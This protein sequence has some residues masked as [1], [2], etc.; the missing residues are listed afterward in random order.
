[1]IFKKHLEMKRRDFI[2]KSMA[3]TAYAALRT[4]APGVPHAGAARA[5][6]RDM[7]KENGLLSAMESSDR[8]AV[9]GALEKELRTPD[10]ALKIH[11]KI[12]PIA[13]RVLNPPFI[14][15]HLPK[16][17]G[18][19]RELMALVKRK[20]LPA[21]VGLEVQ[22]YARRPKLPELP[23]GRTKDATVRFQEIRSAIGSRDLEKTAA[24]MAAFHRQAGGIQLA[25]QL[26]LLGSGYLDNSLGHSV[27]CTAFM[28]L[29]MLHRENQDPWP[30]LAALADY[31]CKGRYHERP[32][33]RKSP[34]LSAEGDLARYILSA[35]SGGGIVNLHHTITFYAIERVKH[36][37]NEEE[38]GHMLRSWIAFMGRKEVEEV[39]IQSRTAR[40]PSGYGEFW[41]IF[42]KMDATSVIGISRALLRSAQGLNTLARFLIKG[43]CDKYDGDYNPHYL[44][45]LG[46][47]LYMVQ[48]YPDNPPIWESALY[49]YL[50][51][52]FD[53]MGAS[54]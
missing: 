25:R 31:F 21:L 53:G 39:E 18:I 22:E 6:G 52:F 42:S 46:S 54:S 15:P 2:H 33:Y 16:M 44:T 48:H 20:D 27:S 41:D 34:G 32:S 26:L 37:L 24:L 23:R 10:D 38:Y 17:Y 19:Y 47:S 29:E 12:F 28:L 43:L 40:A 30:I 49:Q 45:G 50:D 51:F 7:T 36:L 8:G 4:L 14:N 1:M 11:L 3:C 13:E 35:T 5:E 9:M